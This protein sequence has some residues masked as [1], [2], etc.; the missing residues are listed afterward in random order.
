[1]NTHKAVARVLPIMNVPIFILAN[2]QN[3]RFYTRVHEFRKR[4]MTNIAKI[5]TSR[6]INNI[7]NLP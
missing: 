4:N 7:Y 6:K 3:H 2:L 1:M 5:R